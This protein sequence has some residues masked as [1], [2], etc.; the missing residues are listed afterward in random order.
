MQ[1]TRRFPGTRTDAAKAAGAAPLNAD[2]AASNA[3]SGGDVFDAETG[4]APRAQRIPLRRRIAYAGIMLGL[5]YGVAELL[6]TTL[7][8]ATV[9]S[10][11]WL[12]EGHAPEVRFDPK[13]GYRVTGPAT[14]VA[15]FGRAEDPRRA[16]VE[17]VGA[18]EGNAQGFPDRDDFS[19]ERTTKGARRLVV[20]G[21]SFSGGDL[22][23]RW[24]D[25]CE[26]ASRDAGAA[27]DLLNFSHSGFGL[28]NWHRMLTTI[29]APEGYDVDGV[30]FAV[31]DN[32]LAR[33]FYVCD[34][35]EGSE[36]LGGRV[37]SWDPADYPATRE[38]ALRWM[39]E[40]DG[41]AVPHEDFE[42]AL[43]GEWTPPRAWEPF[44]AKTVV[45][46]LTPRRGGSV[47]AVP[48]G[49]LAAELADTSQGRGLLVR[50][51]RDTLHAFQGTGRPAIVVRI[52]TL[53]DLL[54]RRRAPPD[55]DSRAFANYLGAPFL[56]GTDAWFG[57]SEEEIRADWHERDV[58]WA[59][60]GSDRFARWMATRLAEWKPSAAG[61]APLAP[62]GIRPVF[63]GETR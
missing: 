18:V 53:D 38:E 46:A 55:D 32:D 63:L 6:A 16:H 23:I 27:A 10:T 60:S 29:V 50:E 12:Y 7:Y 21:D 17:Y 4:F 45:E 8:R 25:R 56:D 31:W 2:V 14:R 11:Y 5:A 15:K 9:P 54:A 62:H 41:R 34:M 42:R 24:P 35:G 57:L 39:A 48:P 36:R 47:A 19:A 40:W 33:R 26:D 49:R 59:Q 20:F 43:A 22:P 51:I 52:P 58:H 1:S 28:A 30:V 44:I 3:G 37:Q 13:S 61:A